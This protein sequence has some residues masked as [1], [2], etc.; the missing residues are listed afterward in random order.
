MVH[1]PIAW[2]VQ[3]AGTPLPGVYPGLKTAPTQPPLLPS[4]HAFLL[5]AWEHIKGRE[6]QALETLKRIAAETA[7]ERLQK[8]GAV[9]V[10]EAAALHCRI[11]PARAQGI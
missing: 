3:L 10:C 4:L 11:A 7:A 2:R 6:G 5:Q 1:Q 8:E 9:A